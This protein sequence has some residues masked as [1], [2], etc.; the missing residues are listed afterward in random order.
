MKQFLVRY[1]WKIV[2]V[3]LGALAGFLYW[4]YIG[5]T[6]GTCPI[7][8]NWHTST[9]YGALIG[10][11]FPNSPGKGKKESSAKPENL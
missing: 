5:C 6:S 4:Y 9:L 11:V 3:F 1:K 8:S 7:Q 10:Y 2:G